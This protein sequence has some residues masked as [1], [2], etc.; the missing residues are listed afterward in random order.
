MLDNNIKRMLDMVNQAK[1]ESR[2]W[3]SVP[4]DYLRSTLARAS[5]AF[6]L[7]PES[8]AH[9]HET[10]VPGPVGDIRVR[11][12]HPDPTQQLPVVL[13]FH[14]GGFVVYDLETHDS[15]CRVIANG[16]QCV[17]VAVEYRLAPEHK[18]PSAIEDAEAVL[19]WARDTASTWGGLNTRIGVMGDSAGGN[20]ASVLCML[21][22]YDEGFRP[23]FQ[24]LVYPMLD[25]RA[26][27][28]SRRLFA[29][30][31]LLDSPL[32][33]FFAKSY[34]NHPAE[35]RDERVSPALCK[36]L[37]HFPATLIFTAGYDQVR[38]EGE[39]FFH[40]LQ[41]AGVDVRYK[42]Y[43]ALVHNFMQ[44][45]KIPA[46]GKALS[47]IASAVGSLAHSRHFSAC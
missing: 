34:L 28:H 37:T 38:D 17:V 16:A 42:C 15:I 14:G 20:I 26:E 1:P 40:R 33:E 21:Y 47:E 5:T 13:F 43:E 2:D 29:S 19:I 18:F 32:V 41:A 11:I 8:V 6:N 44:L 9:I 46:A 45:G 24:C 25:A 36:D 23:D 30:G 12:Y 22:Q 39:A 3:H 27:T 7:P 35:A 31:F 10:N 4:M